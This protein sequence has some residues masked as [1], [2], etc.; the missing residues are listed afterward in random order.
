MLPLIS[1]AINGF[2]RSVAL[3]NEF[4]LQDTLRLLTLWFKYG[5]HPEVDALLCAGFSSLSPDTWLQVLPQVRLSSPSA[6]KL[7]TVIS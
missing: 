2:F 3:D 1:A 6:L 5:H 7:L 4:G